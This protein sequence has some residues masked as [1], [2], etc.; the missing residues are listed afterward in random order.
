M[1][2]KKD[3]FCVIK[4]SDFSIVGLILILMRE[5]GIQLDM[6]N[7]KLMTI[8]INALKQNIILRSDCC[9]DLIIS[10]LTNDDDDDDDPI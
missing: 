6:G 4:R 10:S 3:L 9:T 5:K 7:K 8:K 1:V 2:K